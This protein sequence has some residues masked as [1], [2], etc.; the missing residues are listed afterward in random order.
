M[1]AE[2]AGAGFAGSASVI[3]L[4]QRGWSVRMH[5]KET[6]RAF[7]AGIF[8]WETPSV[9]MTMRGKHQAPAYESRRDGGCGRLRESEWAQPL[10][11]AHDDAPA[12]LFGHSRRGAQARRGDLHAL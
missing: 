1:H 3:A 12:P 9:P 11:P 8:V 6:L 7:G 10:S 4:R 5:E 2:I